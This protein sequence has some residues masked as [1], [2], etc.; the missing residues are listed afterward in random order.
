MPNEMQGRTIAILAADGTMRDLSGH[1]SEIDGAAL[2]L[3]AASEAGQTATP[4][5]N[6]ACL[7]LRRCVM[8][9]SQAGKAPKCAGASHLPNKLRGKPGP[10]TR[11]P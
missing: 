8:G 4:P 7:H 9:A 5:G 6:F 10:R 3:A 1:V 2:Q 11:V